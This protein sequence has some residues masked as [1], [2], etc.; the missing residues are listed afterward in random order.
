MRDI[1]LQMGRNAYLLLEVA[2]GVFVGV[3]EEVQYAV[4]DVI[5]LQVVHQVG[6]VTLKPQKS[7]LMQNL[8]CSLAE[9]SSSI[10]APDFLFPVTN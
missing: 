6:A 3:R 5:L 7:M 4:L 9:N 8:Q 10:F 2:D 1:S